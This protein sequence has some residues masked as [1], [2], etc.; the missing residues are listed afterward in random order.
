MNKL[1][2]TQIAM[3]IFTVAVGIVAGV[4]VLA[5]IGMAL[6]NWGLMLVTFAFKL[7]VVSAVFGIVGGAIEFG[8]DTVRNRMLNKV[9]DAEFAKA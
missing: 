2:K 9:I 1:T 5:A 8:I 4:I 7:M 3:R 6:Q